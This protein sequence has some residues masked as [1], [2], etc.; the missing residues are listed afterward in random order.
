MSLVDP[1][2]TFGVDDD[3]GSLALQGCI[4]YCGSLAEVAFLDDHDVGGLAEVMPPGAMESFAVAAMS[5]REHGPSGDQSLG[6]FGLSPADTEKFAIAVMASG[7]HSP[8]GDQ[9]P[10]SVRLSPADLDT[11]SEEH[12][13]IVVGAVGA[14]GT[15]APWFL[16]GW[17]DGRDGSRVYD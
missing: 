13:A 14:V 9:S 12:E 16:T 11:L 6:S 15:G 7:E 10:V 1:C 4:V 17:M 3:D 8:S 5:H 2:E